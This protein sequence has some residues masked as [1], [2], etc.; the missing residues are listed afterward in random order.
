MQAL[1]GE[2]FPAFLAT[3]DEPSS[4]GLRVNTLKLPAQDFAA[5][6]PYPLKPVDWCPEGF[7]LSPEQLGDTKGERS[8][9]S[10]NKQAASLF[11]WAPGKHPYHAAGLY[12]LQDPAAM[13]AAALL[14][15]QPGER[16][17]DLCG[18]PGGKSTHIAA[19]MQGRGLLVANE[20]HPKRAWD[21]AENLE[22]FGVRN[23]AIT[24]ETPE[25]LAAHFG[26]FFDRVLLDAPCSGE[27]MFRKSAA[28][29]DEWSPDLVRGCA[30]RQAGILEQAARLVRPGGLLAYV[31]CTFAPEEDE[32]QL[33]RFLDPHNKPQGPRFELIDSPQWPG[34]SPGRPEWSGLPDAGGFE[35][36]KAVRMWP[37]KQAG[38]GHF[39][40][41][42]RRVDDS[43]AAHLPA[44]QIRIPRDVLSLYQKFSQENLA[45]S[46]DSRALALQGQY[47]YHL[48]AGMPELNGL[49]TIH[50]GWWLGEVKKGRFEP[51]HA[52]ALGLQPGDAQRILRLEPDSQ[53]IKAYLRGETLES[54]GENG[55]VLVCVV[56][57]A[58]D[59]P[60]GWGRRVDSRLKNHYPKG[61]RMFL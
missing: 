20:I 55:W 8:P 42:L 39:I 60:V 24:Q 30:V 28:A 54:N 10:M 37:H 3:Y 44:W 61:L 53:E 9:R 45:G 56:S 31:T 58:G 40:A 19:R 26:A 25:R 15:P 5:A 18:A 21:L 35:L 1:L 22:R 57:P 27:G 36:Q 23:A 59:F 16:I 14:D 41:L 4:A 43:P 52:L 32:A 12:Y 34:F 13:A 11:Y 50:P 46:P 6:S 49:R 29:R 2:D 33:A 48:P 51:S 17:L 7:W 47:L 38:D